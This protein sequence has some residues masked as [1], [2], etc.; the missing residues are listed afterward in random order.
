[1]LFRAI[2][3]PRQRVRPGVLIL[4]LLLVLISLQYS[5]LSCFAAPPIEHLT[6]AEFLEQFQATV[7][8]KY[9]F[10]FVP[11][12]NSTVKAHF[13]AL[14]EALL[15]SDLA[16]ARTE[17]EALD[18]LGVRYELVTVG[19]IAGGPAIGFMERVLP[20]APHYHGWGAALVRPSTTG[21]RV[22]QAPH[23]KAD[24]FSENIVLRAFVDDPNA[25]VALFAGTHRYAN[26]RVRPRSDVA[27]NTDNLFHALT[28]YLARRGQSAGD[29]YWF[30]QIHGS[31]DRSHIP[32][33]VGSNGA[34]RPQLALDSPLVRINGGVDN[35]GY[36]DMGVCGWRE[37]PGDDEDGDYSLCA[38]TNVQGDFLEGLG[39]RQT[40]IHLEL[41]RHVRDDYRAGSG[42]GYDGVLSLLSGVS[43]TLD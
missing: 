26:G 33:I 1:M 40:F 20:G 4:C 28:A 36:V 13:Q 8:A 11:L 42:P 5:I 30:I 19:G 27:H 9:S 35:A 10:T 22:Y 2:F 3:N 14:L 39:L 31:R 41:E 24:T 17:I 25:A 32:S 21:H 43:D 18:S 7:G 29:P 34:D 23:V 12:T 37:G 6:S 38:T 16:A 15:S